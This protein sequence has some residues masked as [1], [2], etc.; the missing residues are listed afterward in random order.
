MAT[1][2][3]KYSLVDK[4]LLPIAVVLAIALLL[5]VLAGNM[6]PRKHSIIA[7][8]GL[9]YPF[10]LFV[11]IIFLVWWFL[12]KKWIFAIA[13]VL[14]ITLGAKTLKATFAIGG[15]EGGTEKADNSIRMMTYNV[16]SF[17][18]YGED[19]TESVKEKMLQVVK[20]QNPDIICFQEF[21][22]RYKG[23]FDTVDS[24]KVLLNTKYY[25]FVPTNKN[26]YE[27]TGLAIFSKFPI[28]DS[29]KIPF[30]EGFPGNMSIYTDL[31]I[32]G[33]T[34]RVYNVHFQ[35]ISFEKQDYEYL[36]KVKEMNTELQ[37]SKR[38]LRMLKSAFLK[39]SG[40]VDIMKKEMATCK[41]PYLIAGDFN[42][43]PASYVVTQ[44]TSGLNNSF[45]KKGN[46]FG[47]TYNGKFPNFQIDYI[48]TS[49]DL[50]V[51]NYKITQAKLSD[52]FPV[53]S[54]L[55]FLP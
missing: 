9:A 27:A 55:R 6:D 49:K 36:D 20:D 28:K 42:D 29:G 7:F 23:A 5:G 12:S 31:N 10:V 48:A 3:N 39:R 22:T 17:K 24:L 18:L 1:K 47:K 44:I 34:L 2:K 46:G 35:S 45:I 16:H 37:P 19:N 11:N 53:R 15:D 30:V 26:D 40:Q 51:L 50:E 38:I 32:K 54:D 52:H 41:T 43:T 33:K 4:L 14:V 25:Y 21:F 13:T 8:F